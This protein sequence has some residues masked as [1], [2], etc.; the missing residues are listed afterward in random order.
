[1]CFFLIFALVDS[2]TDKTIMSNLVAKKGTDNLFWCVSMHDDREAFNVLFEN[3]YPSLC[4]YAKRYMSELPIREDVVQDVFFTLWEKRKTIVIETSLK[5]YLISAVKNA[6]LNYLK[7]ENRYLDYEENAKERLPLYAENVDEI[8]NVQELT[9]LL[10]NAL[11]KLPEEYRIAFIMSRFED[12]DS[13][14]IADKMG[15]SVRSVERYRARAIELL[16]TELKD[17]LPLLIFLI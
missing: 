12:K 9:E 13:K 16:R 14:E 1:M 11:N 3:Y 7:R 2:I 6:C 8:Y 17:Y 5:S 10:A 4:L 15:V